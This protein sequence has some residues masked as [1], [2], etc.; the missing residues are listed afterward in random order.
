MVVRAGGTRGAAH[1]GIAD[2]GIPHT[3]E[4]G[5][6]RQRHCQRLFLP[7]L[8]A[9]TEPL[10]ALGEPSLKAMRRHGHGEQVLA[11]Q[12]SESALTSDLRLCSHYRLLS[13]GTSAAVATA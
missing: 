2:I 3:S 7:Q 13:E 5:V 1:R 4:F 11:R 8:Q 6:L 10:I 12:T 9:I